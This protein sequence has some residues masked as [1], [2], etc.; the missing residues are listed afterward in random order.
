MKNIVGILGWLGIALV[1]AALYVRF[2]PGVPDT[3]YSWS[4]P[5]A[6]AGLV[7]TALYALTQWRD[8]QRSFQKRGMQF[9]S[10]A[11]GSVVMFLA[12]LVGINWISSR[13]N[14]RWDW[15]QAGQFSMSEQTKQLLRSLQRPVKI[16][17]FYGSGQDPQQYRD[18][19]TEYR[20]YSGHI[21]AE[22]VEA[23]RNPTQAEK[24]GITTVPTVL[25]EYEG[26]TERSNQADEQGITNA[27]KKAVEGKAKKAYF[28]QGHGE[29]D[30]TSGEPLGYKT[31]AD[32]MAQDNFEVAK[33][34][35]PQEGKIPEDA[36]LIVVAGPTID[37]FAPEIEALKAFLKRGGKLL[38]ML[39]P[40]GRTA[41]QPLTNLIALAREWGMNVGND[42]VVDASGMGRMIGTDA[43]VPLAA[44]MPH[45]ITRD[46]ATVITGYPLARSVTPIEG[47]ADGKFAQGITQ[48]TAQSWAETDIK[49][50]YET[51]KPAP[52]PAKGDRQ[53]PITLA[54]ASSAAA[55]DA[56]PAPGAAPDAPKPETRVVVVGDSD[57][58]ANRAI[59]IGV[60][61]DLFL[62]MSNWL[63]QQENLISI[64]PKDPADRRIQLTSDQHTLLNILALAVIP[65]LLFATAFRV[66]WKRR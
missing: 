45:A 61:K 22:F 23:D 39:D 16:R 36:T 3:W 10:V 5:L 54:A 26:R 4:R 40:P 6:L 38:L 17:V 31:A 33:L 52:E 59:A 24:Y 47:G 53:G 9:G 41:T 8:I 65:G 21:D 48:T 35:L 57:F 14:K 55:P 32:S 62:N 43:S 44:P 51:G 7:V 42:V 49:G 18:Q 20:Y 50:L 37:F 34:P 12:V 30:P 11:I 46:M 66:W 60:N 28:V 19:M 58:A 25:I 64:R 15:T 56:P 63:A 27:L 13:Q 29:K 2:G 1:T